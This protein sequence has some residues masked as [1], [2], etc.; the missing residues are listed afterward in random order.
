MDVPNDRLLLMVIV[1]TGFVV[2]T[3]A[4]AAGLVEAQLEGRTEV[5]A[6]VALGLLFVAVLVMFWTGFRRI[7]RR[8]E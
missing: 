6:F 4:L 2:L 8:Q 1:G 3:G 5:S 7:D